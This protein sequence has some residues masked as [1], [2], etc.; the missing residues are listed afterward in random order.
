MSSRTKRS[1]RPIALRTN[2]YAKGSMDSLYFLR[3]DTLQ[4]AAGCAQRDNAT[5][6]RRFDTK[7][8]ESTHGLV[9]GDGPVHPKCM[10]SLVVR[11]KIANL[12]NR[13]G[14]YLGLLKRP[15]CELVPQTGL[16]LFTSKIGLGAYY[17]E[18][19][20]G[21]LLAIIGLCAVPTS[22]THDGGPGFIHCL[23]QSVGDKR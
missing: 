22:C 20:V 17:S 5:R 2:C 11:G 3:V 21:C 7:L 12:T 23:G 14:C 16:G 15:G 9:V 6:S 10:A 13:E 4:S 8:T 19:W 1:L 18:N